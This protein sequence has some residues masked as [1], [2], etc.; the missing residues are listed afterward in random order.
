MNSDDKYLQEYISIALKNNPGLQS[1]CEDNKAVYAQKLQ[2]VSNFFPNL[3]LNSRYSRAGGGRT[4][5][6]PLGTMFNPVF[7]GL[8]PGSN[9]MLPDVTVNLIPQREQETKVS[10]TQILFSAPVYFN[11][12]MMGRLSNAAQHELALK[13]VKTVYQVYEAYYTFAKAA[14]LAAI[15]QGSLNL[16]LDNFAIV[17]KL[18]LAD[19]ATKSDLLRAEVHCFTVQQEMQQT[20]NQLALARNAFNAVLNRNFDA[21]IIVD[22]VSPEI[23]FNENPQ[24]RLPFIRYGTAEEAEIQALKTRPELTRISSGIEA[25]QYGKKAVA[26]D[27]FPSLS[28]A[29]DYGFQDE[30]YRFTKDND[31]WMV[32]GVMTWNIFSGGRTRYK[33]MEAEATVQS[34]V[35]Q[36]ESAL[37]AIRLEVKNAFINL[38]N[39][40]ELLVVSGKTYALAR[41]NY[42]IV[43]SRYEQGLEPLIQLID[44]QTAFDKAGANCIVTYYNLLLSDALFR[45]SVGT[46]IENDR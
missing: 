16:A 4:F 38:Q 20:E 12:R 8:H 30:K 27:Y 45:K 22:T 7:N 17:K 1:A 14:Q 9:I 33:R 18:S 11:Y 32:S 46:L 35:K 3:T 25:A 41:E 19:R 6:L 10:A 2:A 28:A 13:K 26:G 24:L 5:A 42:R 43:K 40:G 44:A 39:T 31:F 23:I 37:Q 34:L 36:Y 15:E 21:E 29:A